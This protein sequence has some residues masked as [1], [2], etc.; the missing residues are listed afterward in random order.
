[1][2]THIVTRFT[3][4][5]SSA[6]RCHIRK[7][8][9]CSFYLIRIAWV[10]LD[11]RSL[12]GWMVT[13]VN[14][15]AYSTWHISVVSNSCWQQWSNEYFYSRRPGSG[16]SYSTDKFPRSMHS[17]DSCCRLH[18]IYSTDK[19]MCPSECQRLQLESLTCSRPTSQLTPQQ[20][21]ACVQLC[22]KGVIWGI[23]CRSAQ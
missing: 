3:V 10:D 23:E 19:Q 9:N 4:V 14:C 8:H 16:R 2:V 15:F 20:L 5:K 17:K 11:C 12:K 18:S 22:R 1:M 7:T 21:C 6:S 13:S